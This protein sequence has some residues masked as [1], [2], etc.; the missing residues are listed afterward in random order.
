MRIMW[1][2]EF[3]RRHLAHT[4]NTRLLLRWRVLTYQT[5]YIH[6]AAAAAAAAAAFCCCRCCA[7]KGKKR[8]AEAAF[9]AAIELAEHCEFHLLVALA[10]RDLQGRVSGGARRWEV[11]RRC[12]PCLPPF[13][14][15]YRRCH[16]S[17]AIAQAGRVFAKV[18]GSCSGDGLE[19]W[20]LCEDVFGFM[21]TRLGSC[22]R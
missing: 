6:V 21:F 15:I 19:G 8:E 7:P 1:H 12:V 13:A 4:G 2:A 3:I 22:K 16:I 18:A 20:R 5:R 17:V 10:L 14:W 11:Q 9:E